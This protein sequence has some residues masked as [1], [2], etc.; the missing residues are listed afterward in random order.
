MSTIKIQT[1]ALVVKPEVISC[2]FGSR[3]TSLLSLRSEV[4]TLIWTMK[5]MRNLRQF[6][7]TFTTDCSQL[8]KMVLEPRE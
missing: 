7:V 4:E 6:R 8:V 5:C 3:G 2:C 1:Y